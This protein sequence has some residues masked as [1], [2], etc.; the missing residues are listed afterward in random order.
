MSVLNSK[1]PGIYKETY[2]FLFR[3]RQSTKDEKDNTYDSDRPSN[4]KIE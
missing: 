4:Q 2:F 3:H 1:Q